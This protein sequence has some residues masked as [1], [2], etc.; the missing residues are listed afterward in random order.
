MVAEHDIG[1]MMLPA[2]ALCLAMVEA[3]FALKDDLEHL[4]MERPGHHSKPIIYDLECSSLN[5]HAGWR[6][7][8]VEP[9]S[10]QLMAWKA[11]IARSGPSIEAQEKL[12][13]NGS[14]GLCTG[15][16]LVVAWE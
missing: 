4:A 12:M 7:A 1:A 13:E 15:A 2:C 11:T 14:L 5:G 10:V 8:G 3:A 9:V 16:M 6:L